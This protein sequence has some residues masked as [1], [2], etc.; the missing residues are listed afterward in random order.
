MHDESGQ[1]GEVDGVGEPVKARREVLIDYA[2]LDPEKV[3]NNALI[4]L[5]RSSEASQI[6]FEWPNLHTMCQRL[7]EYLSP[8]FPGLKGGPLIE[9]C[10]KTAID[11]YLVEER[12]GSGDDRTKVGRFV[13]GLL[14]PAPA[15][16]KTLLYA[17]CDDERWRAWEFFSQPI[18][19]WLI[20]NYSRRV[21]LVRAERDTP[22]PDDCIAR[23]FLCANIARPSD[24]RLTGEIMVQICSSSAPSFVS[25]SLPNLS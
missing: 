4:S 20:K 14:A 8:A 9:D 11:A 1:S 5:K 2:C 25:A 19:H 22:C 16:F 23:A 24:F 3:L 18:S 10:L 12:R 21:L 17:Q 7:V 13:L 6:F 15:I